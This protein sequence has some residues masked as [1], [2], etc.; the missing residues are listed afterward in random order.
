MCLTEKS[1]VTFIDVKLAPDDTGN[2]E[3]TCLQQL[4]STTSNKDSRFWRV[5]Y[6]KKN[7]QQLEDEETVDSGDK[8]LVAPSITYVSYGSCAQLR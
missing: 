8:P 3:W 7:D 1:I 5:L 2:V 6:R 4:Y